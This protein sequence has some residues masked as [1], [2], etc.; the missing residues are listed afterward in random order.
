MPTVHPTA[1]VEDGAQL[2]DDVIVG[3]YAFIGPEVKVAEGTRLD[4][5]VILQGRTS[6]GPHNH[7]FPYAVVGSV[8]QD[9]KYEGEPAAVE[10]GAHNQIREHVTIHIGTNLGGNVTRIG[11]HNLIMAGAH[12]GHDCVVG[13]HCVL[14]NYTGL[15]GHVTV[16]DYAILGGQTGVHQFVK[17]GAHCIT[18]GGSKVGK[19]IAPYTVAQ[20]YPARLRGINHVGLK[21]RGFSDQTVRLLRQAYRAVFFAAEAKFDE[22]LANARAEFKGSREVGKFLDFLEEASQSDRGFLRPLRSESGSSS[23]DKTPPGGIQAAA[24]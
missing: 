11:D 23:D 20:G 15:A 18:S 5:G 1:I 9:K 17:I 3:P 4:H 14:A 21:R 19:D 7:L 12:V 2:A 24:S 10:I 16:E 13:N 6:V 22:T 8:P